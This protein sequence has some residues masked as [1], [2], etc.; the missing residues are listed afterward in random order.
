MESVII[1]V[2]EKDE[3]DAEHVLGSIHLPLSNFTKQA[4]GILSQLKGKQIIILCR[5]GKRAQVA[6]DQ[7]KALGFDLNS[8][9]YQ[10]GILEWKSQGRQTQ[11]TKKGHRP[12]MQQVQIVA[13][14]LV[15]L[16]VLATFFIDMRFAALAGFV[17]AGLLFAGLS[18]LC[19][20][21]ELLARMPWNKMV[22]TTQKELCE[23]SPKSSDCGN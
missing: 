10:G 3:F 5:S 13:G 1:D 18:G 2:R 19:F 23:V 11:T 12:L 16:S 9:V 20:M 21:A 17:G 15:L 8:K 7:I 4:P 6:A 14:S 22:E